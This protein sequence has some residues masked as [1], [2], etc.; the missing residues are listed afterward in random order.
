MLFPRAYTIWSERWQSA[1]EWLE[2]LEK[3]V[4]DEGAVSA[5]GGEYDDWDLMVRGGALGFA[6]LRSLVEEH[7][8]GKQLI[9]FRTWPGCTAG[10]ILSVAGFGALAAAAGFAHAWTACGI[11]SAIALGIAARAAL[12]CATAMTRID[13]A[14]ER[15]S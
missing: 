5:R 13:G 9:R 14:M 4:R 2:A 12:E 15:S 1:C 10:G 8:A 6:R 7:G 3:R 11:L